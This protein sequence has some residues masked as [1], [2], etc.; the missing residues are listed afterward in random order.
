ML[1]RGLLLLKYILFL[2][3]MMFKNYSSKK[4]ICDHSKTVVSFKMIML[5]EN[6]LTTTII[7]IPIESLLKYII[8]FVLPLIIISWFLVLRN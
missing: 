7:V 3:L 8:I 4:K 1:D 5:M 2:S 6:F